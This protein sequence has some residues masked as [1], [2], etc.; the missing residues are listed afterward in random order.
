MS[1]NNKEDTQAK[2]DRTQKNHNMALVRNLNE[3]V[4]KLT[5]QLSRHSDLHP[6]FVVYKKED[7]PPHRAKF[8]KKKRKIIDKA[9]K[10]LCVLND[11][12]LSIERGMEQENELA[13][14]TREVDRLTALNQ[15]ITQERDAILTRFRYEQLM[16]KT[17]EAFTPPNW[18][19]VL[20]KRHAVIPH[21][22]VLCVKQSP[23]RPNVDPDLAITRVIE[24]KKE[25]PK[26]IVWEDK[27]ALELDRL[28][29]DDE[30]SSPELRGSP[31]I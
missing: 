3:S 11:C 6:A 19:E 27:A 18:R 16:N 30:S 24:K 8:L 25:A 2:K 31:E 12:F 9:A 20:E 26:S 29:Y 22:A 7:F 15:R 13:D 28:L 23:P 5:N 21:P 10:E 1:N 4:V 14:L 17:A